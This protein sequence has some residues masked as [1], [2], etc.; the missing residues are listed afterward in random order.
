MS[1]Q[2]KARGEPR[3]FVGFVVCFGCNLSSKRGPSFILEAQIESPM[4][5]GLSGCPRVCR[6]STCPTKHESPH[7]RALRGPPKGGHELGL[8]G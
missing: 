4:A 3:R 6:P 1:R 7:Q 2:G 5:S 8:L